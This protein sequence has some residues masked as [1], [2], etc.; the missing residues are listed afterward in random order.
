MI[1]IKNI[2]DELGWEKAEGYPVGTRIKTLRD[3]MERKLYC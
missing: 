3:E 2:Y 1:H